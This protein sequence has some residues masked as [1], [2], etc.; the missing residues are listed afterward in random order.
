MLDVDERRSWGE[1][2]ED[3]GIDAALAVVGLVMDREARNDRVE[4]RQ[5]AHVVHPGGGREVDDSQV[6]GR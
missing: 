6:M 5:I 4:W 1:Q 2:F 3:L